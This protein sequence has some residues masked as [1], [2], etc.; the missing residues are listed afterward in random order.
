[1]NRLGQIAL[2]ALA[3][4]LAACVGAGVPVGERAI[5]PDFVVGGGSWDTGGVVFVMA[6][7]ERDAGQLVICGAWTV[8]SES[9]V[10][11]FDTPDIVEAGSILLAGDNVLHG[12]KRFT[13]LDGT[14]NLRGQ[15]AACLRSGR[16]WRPEYENAAPE[17]RLVRRAID[18]DDFSGPT[19]IF[20]PGP[21]PDILAR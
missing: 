21:V 20:T 6:R 15:T 19:A 16:P 17:V 13:R 18:F 5:D 7:A 12:L 4:P 2:L 11:I 8:V 3:S 10:T 14:E 9:S 1:M